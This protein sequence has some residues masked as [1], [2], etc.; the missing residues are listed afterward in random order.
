M[1]KWRTQFRTNN[2]LHLESMIG[3]SNPQGHPMAPWMVESSAEPVLK[4]EI[5]ENG[6]GMNN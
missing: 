2:K 4:F 3:G 5:K 6:G 1:A